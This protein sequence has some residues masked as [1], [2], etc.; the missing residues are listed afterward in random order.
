MR[1]LSLIPVLVG[2]MAALACSD[3]SNTP[4]N[5]CS[6]SGGGPVGSVTVGNNFFRSDHNGT[7]NTAVDT[8]AAGATVT[9]TWTGTTSHSVRS[10]GATSFP[11]SDVLTGAGQTYAVT[12]DTPGTYEYDC[13]VHA[14]Q[15]TGRVVVQ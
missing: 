2:V 6:G 11:S 1:A 10:Q 8:V 5:D 13:S 4:S 9:W 15:M 14:S 12:F 7:C 3:D